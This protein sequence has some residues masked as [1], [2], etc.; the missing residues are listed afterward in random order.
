MARNRNGNK[1]KPYRN[2]ESVSNT[3]DHKYIKNGKQYTDTTTNICKS[4]L[5]SDAFKDLTARQRMLYVYAKSQYYGAVNRP[6]SE[7]KELEKYKADGGKKYFFLNHHLI[8][9]VFALYPKS[10][11][12]DFYND[13][14]ILIN[15]GFIEEDTQHVRGRIARKIYYYSDKWREW[16]K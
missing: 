12:R 4:M 3:V 15:H 6:S 1:T 2:F 11:K 14:N 10:N 7:Y 16:E 5:L 9:E 13:I 8:T